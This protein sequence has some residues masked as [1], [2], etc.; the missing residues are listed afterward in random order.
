MARGGTRAASFC[1]ETGLLAKGYFNYPVDA[2][3]YYQ[4]RSERILSKEGE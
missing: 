1:V 2:P 3:Y 4:F